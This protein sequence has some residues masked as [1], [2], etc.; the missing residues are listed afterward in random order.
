[1]LAFHGDVLG[2][3]L[4]ALHE[5]GQRLGDGRLRS[6]RIGGDDLDAAEPGPVGRGTVAVEYLCRR[7]RPGQ[8]NSSSF[9]MTTA[10]AGHTGTQMPQPLQ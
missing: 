10:F 4:P 6:D 7:F 5:L 8:L 9:T 1:V 3:E 2:V